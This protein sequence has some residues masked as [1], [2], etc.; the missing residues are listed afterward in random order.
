MRFNGDSAKTVTALEENCDAD[1]GELKAILSGEGKTKWEHE[2]WYYNWQY[3]TTHEY[4][5]VVI[6]RLKQA[7]DGP[8]RQRLLV[9]WS[10][11]KKTALVWELILR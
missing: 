2:R 8:A 11:D 5:N 6:G 7:L 3:I 1:T 4:Q 10:K 9:T